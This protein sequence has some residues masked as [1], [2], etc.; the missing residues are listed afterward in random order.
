MGLFDYLRR[1]NRP[2]KEAR[3]IILGLDNAGKTTILK[4]LSKED[5]THVMPSKGFN[6]KSLAQGQFKPGQVD[7]AT[8]R[9]VVA[10]QRQ[11]NDLATKSKSQLGGTYQGSL[12]GTCLAYLLYVPSISHSLTNL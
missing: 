5:I 8:A 12:C 1:I 6:V 7:D 10:V 3:L 11:L 4:K 2:G 9:A